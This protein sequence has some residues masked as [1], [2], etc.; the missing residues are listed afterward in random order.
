MAGL[1]GL[2]RELVSSDEGFEEQPLIEDLWAVSRDRRSLDEFLAVWGFHG[3]AEGELS[4]RVWREDPSPLEPIVRAYRAKPE[5]ENP[6]TLKHRQRD[7]LR[8]ADRQLLAGQSF[9]DRLEIRFLIWGA[10]TF[11]P[12]PSRPVRRCAGGRGVAACP[13]CPERSAPPLARLR[14][15]CS[16]C[17]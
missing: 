1:S 11:I 5:S 16:G 9:L 17:R 10:R 2:D 14:G 7:A 3:H 8:R 13:R 12:A 6:S 15:S 4:S